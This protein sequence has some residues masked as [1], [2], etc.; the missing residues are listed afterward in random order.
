MLCANLS[1]DS[2]TASIFTK[3][4]LEYIKQNP[5][6]RVQ[7][8][9]DWAPMNYTVNGEPSGY[10]IDFVRLVA[11][12]AGLDVEFINGPTWNEFLEM[13]KNGT[14]D[15]M[16]NIAKTPEREGF[17]EYTTEYS[18][19]IDAVFTKTERKNEFTKLADLKGKKVIVI[20]GFFEE[21][22]LKRY[23]PEIELV[24]ADDTVSALKA[25]AFGK[26]DAM[27]NSLQVG[28]YVMKLQGI[29]G[30]TPAFE[31]DDPRFRIGLHLVAKK[32]N[33]T[34]RNILEKAKS[35]ITDKELIELSQKW[36]FQSDMENKRVIF[37]T[38]EERSYIDEKK[39][40]PL[41]ID[42]DWEPYE[43]V[44]KNGEYK[45]ISADLIK[46]IGE[47]AGIKMP[48]LKTKD[49][50]ETLE[51]S[52]SGKCRV[53]SFLN[54]TPKR[55]EWLIF[56]EPIYNDPNVYIT[57]EEHPYIAD[58]AAFTN[59]TM[60]L[61]KGT[62]IEERLRKDFPQ[63][64]IITVPTEKECLEAVLGGKAD[65]TMRSLTMA[66]YTIKK[67]GLFNLKIAGQNNKYTN[68][69]RMGVAKSEPILREILDKSIMTL[70]PQDKEMI[71][72]KYVSIN[73]QQGTDY[74][75]VFKILIGGAIFFA[76]FFYWN[77]KLSTLNK[78]L[79]IAKE[80]AEIA[81]R[82]KS[83]FLANM[84]HEIRT[85][86]NAI[87]GMTYLINQTELT[88]TQKDYVRKI[89]ISANALLGIIN[90]ILD[91]SKIEAGKLE[92]DNIDFDLHSV[93]EN[94]TMLVELK[95]YEKGL[96]FVVSYDHSM[97]TN[98]HGDPLRLSQILTNLSNNAVKF[99]EKG[100]VGIYISKV[101]EGRFRFE[102]RDTGIGL[103]KE[104][105]NR[106]FKS[107]SQAD[108]STTRKFGGTGLGLAI[109]KQLVELMGGEIWVESELGVGSSFIFEIDLEERSEAKKETK[110]FNG[111]R[112]L[113]V[114]DTPSWQFILSRHLKNFNI[115]VT[116][117]N[118]GDEALRILQTAEIPFDLIFMDWKMPKM[119][120]LETTKKIKEIQGELPP[121]VVMV[122][123]HKQ[124]SVIEEAK[125]VGIEV[126]LQKPINPS[127]LQ[128]VIINIFG[129][130]IKKEL[131]NS[132][133]SI[134]LKNELT[135]LDGS[136]ILLVEDN[137]MNKEIVLGMLKDSG[138]NIDTA[139]NG[140]EA[141][142]RYKEGSGKYELILMDIQMPVMDGYE[143]TKLIREIN[144]EIPIIALT[145]NAMKS[146]LERTRACGMNEHLNKPI[147]V[148]KLFGTLLK[149]IP[150]K[151]ERKEKAKDLP[152]K[153]IEHASLKSINT[154]KGL[155]RMMGDEALYKKIVTDFYKTYGDVK[156]KLGSEEGIRLAHTIKGLSGNIGAEELS[157]AAG[158]LEI[159]QNEQNLMLFEARLG[160][161]IS[162]LKNSPFIQEKEK[163]ETISS[164]SKAEETAMLEKLKE[165][166][167]TRRKN[168]YEPLL[169]S[170]PGFEELKEMVRRYKFKE[171]IE[172]LE[173]QRGN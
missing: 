75:L 81:T 7:S 5:V 161:V 94:V 98:L 50:D 56:T 29:S 48:L 124:E 125:N 159:E 30:I 156:I 2:N 127:L 109:S 142:N 24:F 100:E 145:A 158:T 135:T 64:N 119:D 72:N 154:T 23:Y 112:A 74:A 168:L 57:R 35:S 76:I 15:V 129:E 136:N 152:N 102:V 49:W 22:M 42:P 123:A 10:S 132:V 118:S 55:E 147:E 120:G 91:F 16:V 69:F 41:C 58:L 146:D 67:E 83:S 14:L 128:D 144:K 134:S 160:E 52:K 169:A 170:L 101:K 153:I 95:A 28:I 40:F 107:F 1:A 80:S 138:I 4:E 106:L 173:G 157:K 11:K 73:V 171:A 34:L 79:K 139:D 32:G 53:M 141:L 25:L 36:Y 88:P 47:R 114:D 44:D 45:G 104:Q 46:I 117:A 92:I 150:K 166:L 62:S 163:S 96:E 82:E 31:I 8:E 39:E 84:S 78:E 12:K 110:Y 21:D 97:N 89:D 6:F 65:I 43:W 116:T 68:E 38:D 70:N 37:L 164:L 122:S 60:V 66:A 165:A 167:K 19:I 133:D 140:E 115:E 85:P 27:V 151:C 3:E 162:E 130:G 99:T 86:M 103:S 143:A 93:V 17:L 71:T 77:R 33:L 9:Q 61:P 13:M 90:D 59:E 87:I 105:Q 172:Y 149:Y 54:K 26:G 137:Q 126:Y 20:K 18:A 111:K 108:A 121:T 131:R 113:I 155:E 63:M 148:E 51:A